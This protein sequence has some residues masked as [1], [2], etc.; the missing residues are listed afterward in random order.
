MSTTGNRIVELV[1]CPRCKSSMVKDE[2]CGNCPFVDEEGVPYVCLDES[3]ECKGSV[4]LRYPLSPTGKWFPRCDKHWE[5]RLEI[6]DGINARYP[7]SP[8]SDWSPLDAREAW[9][10]DDY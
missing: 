7:S 6:Q 1:K 5:E 4:E 9:G 3:P 8:P 10:E 2:A